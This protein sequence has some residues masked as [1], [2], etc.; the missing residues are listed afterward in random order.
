MIKSMTFKQ[1]NIIGTILSFAMIVTALVIQLKYELEPCPLCI[2]Q[3]IIY[4]VLGSIFLISVWLPNKKL[5]RFLHVLIITITTLAGLIFSGRHIL[6][7]AKII[8]VPAECGI[9]LNYMFE[10]FPLT[11]AFDLLFQGTGDCSQIDWTLLGVTLPQMAFLGYLFFMIYA[12]LIFKKI[13]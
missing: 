10:N 7:Q 13:R 11:E 3:R 1:A 5:I 9:D 4:I 12:L 6:I 2:T 8:S